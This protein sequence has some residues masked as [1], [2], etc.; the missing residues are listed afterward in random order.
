ML[1]IKM[2]GKQQCDDCTLS[3]LEI[4]WFKQKNIQIYWHFQMISEIKN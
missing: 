1:W 3:A 2:T 4:H